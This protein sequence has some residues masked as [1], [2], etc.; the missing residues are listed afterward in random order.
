[1]NRETIQQ[2]KWI[3]D[4]KTQQ[5]KEKI[6]K[7]NYKIKNFGYKPEIKHINDEIWNKLNW[8]LNIKYKKFIYIIKNPKFVI[9]NYDADFYGWKDK[10][11]ETERLLNEKYSN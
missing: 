9:E 6:F 2:R 5:Q 3:H 1:M 8:N 7:I 10:R 11:E 4:V